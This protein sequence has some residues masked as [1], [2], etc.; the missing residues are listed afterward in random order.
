MYTIEIVTL[1]Y[2]WSNAL[3]PA[4]CELN[5]TAEGLIKLAQSSLA[6]GIMSVSDFMPIHTVLYTRYLHTC[7]CNGLFIF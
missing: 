2:V 4:F 5:Q 7:T 3:I 1:A 6:F